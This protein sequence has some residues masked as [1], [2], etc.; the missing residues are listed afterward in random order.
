VEDESTLHA[1]GETSING[2]ANSTPFRAHG[3]ADMQS[4]AGWF[5]QTAD[6]KSLRIRLSKR[7][8]ALLIQ[9]G[10]IVTIFT[11]NLTLVLYVIQVAKWKGYWTSLR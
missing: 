10:L 6:N 8:R 7:N 3:F 11:T 9:I 5:P 1:S 2:D 4:L